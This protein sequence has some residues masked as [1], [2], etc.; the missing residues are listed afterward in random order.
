MYV[1]SSNNN[2]SIA[3]RHENSSSSLALSPQTFSISLDSTNPLM[4]TCWDSLFFYQPLSH[5]LYRMIYCITHRARQMQDT[6]SII[7]IKGSCWLIVHLIDTPS[8]NPAISTFSGKFSSQGTT[9][10]Q[11]SWEC[12]ALHIG[13]SVLER[14]KRN[15][16]QLSPIL[17][18]ISVSFNV[19]ALGIA[20]SSVR[21][22]RWFLRHWVISGKTSNLH[23]LS[24]PFFPKTDWF[25]RN[26]SH[27]ILNNTILPTTNPVFFVLNAE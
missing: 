4:I 7:I 18:G 9:F 3:R 10:F 27:T 14:C 8:P 5:V 21:S 26:K 12:W 6:L 17:W 19:L 16:L 11:N 20:S 13:N 25:S 22:L 1:C 15:L 24:A 2:G 23:L